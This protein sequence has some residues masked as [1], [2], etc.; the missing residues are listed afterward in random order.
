[1]SLLRY[2]CPAGNPSDS[3]QP[4]EC[5]LRDGSGFGPGSVPG[6]V[7]ISSLCSSGG[8][9]QVKKSKTQRKL[10]WKNRKIPF[11]WTIVNDKKDHL[12]VMNWF[13]GSF[14]VLDK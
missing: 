5:I 2:C 4:D 8:G 7:Y 13:T 3:N 14:R 9:E 10:L 11:F 6:G 12:L 1:M